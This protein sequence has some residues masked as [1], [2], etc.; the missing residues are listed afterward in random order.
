MA[1]NSS[2]S[3]APFCDAL[4]F[5]DYTWFT[6]RRKLIE[7][8]STL[9]ITTSRQVKRLAPDKIKLVKAQSG[10]PL[11]A[12]AGLLRQGR[13]SGQTSISI[14]AALGAN[15][16]ILL[17]FDMKRVA[18]RSHHHD[19]YSSTNDKLYSHDFVPAF[20]GWAKVAAASGIRILNATPNSALKEFPFIS[21]EE[22]LQ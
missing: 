10:V 14:V 2:L 18:G 5:S 3:I 7:A 6:K 9:L 12:G 21:I 8:S 11:R 16:I 1:V 17:G 20:L 4:F 22:V 13:N 19:E 15:P